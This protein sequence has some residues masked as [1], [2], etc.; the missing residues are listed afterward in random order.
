MDPFHYAPSRLR[1]S[2][3]TE[4]SFSWSKTRF[5][6]KNQ[7]VLADEYKLYPLRRETNVPSPESHAEFVSGHENIRKHSENMF[8]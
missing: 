6:F 5:W 3:K 8:S 4:T 2:E 7:V 1:V